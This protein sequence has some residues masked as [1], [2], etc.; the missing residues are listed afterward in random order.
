[1]SAFPSRNL[2]WADEGLREIDQGHARGNR[3]AL[4]VR[5]E[6]QSV[7][8]RLGRF[9]QRHCGK[10]ILFGFLFLIV[11][12]IGL[13]KAKLETN[14]ENLWIEVDGRLEKELEY[15]KKALGEGYG[16]T[17]ELLI[18]TPNEEGTNILTVQA[19]KRHLDILMKVTNVSVD[20]FDQTWTLKDI[21]YTLDLPPMD[22]NIGLDTVSSEEFKFMSNS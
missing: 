1:M 3:T 22:D 12:A 17:N 2:A 19:L 8:K 4:L 9:T 6:L 16:G 14:A 20:L 5:S 18:Q 11:S 21:C 13:I 10:V 7:L 15:T